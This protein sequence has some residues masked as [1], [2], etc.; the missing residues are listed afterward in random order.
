[1]RQPPSRNAL[2]ALIAV[3][4]LTAGA[5]LVRGVL[6]DIYDYDLAQRRK[7]LTQRRYHI[8]M[9]RRYNEQRQAVHDAPVSR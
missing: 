1:M 7:I 8:L 4:A 6:T 5:A 2:A 3:L 9:E